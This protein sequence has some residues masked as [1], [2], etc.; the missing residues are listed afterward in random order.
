MS[1][2]PT[3]RSDTDL[4]DV[5]RLATEGRL[6]AALRRLDGLLG[7]SP[8]ESSR[9]A[10]VSLLRALAREAQTSG[11]PG[12]AIALLE[13][14]V[15]LAPGFADLRFQHAQALAARG[16][17]G[18]ARRALQHAL[19]INPDYL[20][21]Q[22]ELALLDAREGL[23][24]DSLD[25][26]RALADDPR[27]QEPATFQQGLARLQQAQWDEAGS[28]LRRALKLSDPAFDGIFERY[29]AHMDGGEPAH[30][31]QVIRGVLERY[32]G[33]P[34]LH[35][36]LAS[37]ELRDGHPDDAIVSFARALELNPNFHAARIELARALETLGQV[38]QAREQVSHVLETR[39]DD[40]QALE[41][42]ARWARPRR[43]EKSRVDT[44]DKEA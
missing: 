20:A 14:A 15:Q 10:A 34:D 35:F 23:L 11:D 5:Q 36:L 32:A 3:R 26:L 13:T 9:H 29:H 38:E 21:A 25:R 28:L 4:S 16:Q 27:L 18:E 43:H 39:P 12:G 1:P 8:A 33:Y 31:A 37:A 30:A 6:E 41:M 24:G 22:L 40:P 7:P 2:R 19:R 17:R 44:G 42:Q